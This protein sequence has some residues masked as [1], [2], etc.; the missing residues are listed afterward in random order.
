MKKPRFIARQGRCPSGWLGHIVAH[1]MT[2]E[3]ALENERTIEH[4]DLGAHDD[5]L[6]IGFGHGRT[7]SLVARQV[8]HGRL[9]GIDTS[10]LMH[11][12]ATRRN[13][14]LVA[15]GRLQLELGD[16]QWLPFDT[17]SFD[18]IYAVHTLYFWR[19]LAKQLAE[20][21]RVLRPGGRFVLAFR[22]AEDSEA[23]ARFPDSVY[24][25]LTTGQVVQAMA[26]LGFVGITP[27]TQAMG[28]RLISWIVAE[29]TTPQSSL[30][31]IPN[32]I[33]TF[34]EI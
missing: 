4:L 26:D 30:S 32:P 12:L 23:V 13:R 24:R 17:A 33:P 22:P 11:R 10:P 8:S 14:P 5:V 2:S 20:I 3:T 1:V 16:S 25:L 27:M 34:G 21:Q 6:E 29:T 15:A 31:K 19:D 18:K 28:A 7:L 9:A